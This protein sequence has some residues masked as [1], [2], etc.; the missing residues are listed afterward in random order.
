VIDAAHDERSGSAVRH[1]ALVC[2]YS[3]DTS[4]GVQ[5]QVL[6]LQRALS[7]LDHQVTVLAPGP[8]GGLGRT[9]PIP[10]NGSIARMAPH[11]AGAYRTRRALTRIPF[12]VVHLHEP[13]AP[14]ITIPTL[15]LHSAPTVATF[16]AAGER[17]PY[18]WF[19][20]PARRLARRIDAAVAVSDAAAELVHRHLGL[21]CTVLHN[22]IELERFE[23]GRRD[24]RHRSVLF[25]GRH[26][27]RKGLEVLLEAAAGLPNDVAI[28]IGGTGPDSRRLRDRYCGDHRIVWLGQVSEAA[29]LEL[30]HQSAVLCAPSRHGESFGVVL[31]EA[32]AAGL[33]VVA[34]D[35]PGYRELSNGGAAARLVPPGEPAAL[36]RALTRVLSDDHLADSLQTAGLN[37]ARRFSL[38]ALAERYVEIYEGLLAAVR[39][40]LAAELMS[41]QF[42]GPA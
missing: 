35:L 18:R 11:P 14:S 16:H 19:G 4:G 42:G 30:L 15:L 21:T 31:L 28:L 12:D 6:A 40:P 5:H 2:P 22:G 34:S 7:R 8:T 29:K 1:V 39:R 13:L 33:P 41:A 38:G 26:E 10:V 24:R 23:P 9:I 37:Q 36:A 25:L 20:A 32:M 3:L 27:E 17:T